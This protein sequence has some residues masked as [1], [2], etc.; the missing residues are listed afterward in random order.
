MAT[1]RTEVIQR[2]APEIEARKLGLLDSAK[3]LADQGITIPPQLVAEMSDLQVSAIDLARAGIGGYQP[4]LDQAG[5]SLGEAQQAL[6]GAMAGAAPFQQEAAALMR[7]GAAGIPQQVYDVQSSL[8]AAAGRGQAVA[9]LA[10]LG[11]AG[12]GQTLGAQLGDVTQGARTYGAMGAGALEAQQQAQ[13][14]LLEASEQARRQA[15]LGQE[16]FTGTTQAFQPS[17]IGA[18]M[19]AYED[20]AVQQALADVARAGDIQQ[21][22]IGAQAVGA[23]AFGGSR[24]AVAEAEL[25]RNILEQQAR[26]AAQMRAAGFESAAQRAQQSFEAQQARAQQAAQAG[27]QLGMSAEQLAQSGAAQL[28]QQGI[29]AAQVAGQLGLSGEQLAAANAQALASTG[30]NIEQLSSSTGLS[31]AQLAGQL[32]GQSGALGLQGQEMMGQLGQGIGALGAQYGQLGL[33]QGQALGELGIR[34]AGLGELGQQLGQ[35]ETGFLFDLGKQEQAQRQAVLEA[36]RQTQQT[37]LYE[38]YQRLGF[39]SDIYQGAPTTQQAI[40]ASTA[41]QVSP[42]QQILGLGISG[43]SAV[44]GAKQAG[45]F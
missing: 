29:Q 19:S 28:G 16:A 44:A 8:G 3:A 30:M 17:G 1:E 4:Y 6:T 35:R 14:G 25:G 21:Q 23:G 32:A 26:T 5:Y 20:A 36:D 2:E 12:V 40:T 42:A 7:A 31:A 11:G 9:D 39:L 41:P 18:F 38:P 37:Q 24:Q 43:L 10:R 45:L 22:Q 13:A 34:Q 27:A 15:Q 33:S